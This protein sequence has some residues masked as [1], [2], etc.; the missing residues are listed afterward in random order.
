MLEDTQISR[1]SGSSGPGNFFDFGGSAA[2]AGTILK[3]ISAQLR[4]A[5]AFMYL[6]SGA[7]HSPLSSRV[8][9]VLRTRIP[10]FSKIWSLAISNASRPLFSSKFPRS[11]AK[12]RAAAARVSS[13]RHF[14][15]ACCAFNYV[16]P[17]MGKCM[18]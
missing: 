15:F 16:L 3:Q 5:N 9:V 13:A 11:Y 12:Q 7:K 8:Q 17:Q 14:A 6:I 1:F 10:D 4:K 2:S 18:Q